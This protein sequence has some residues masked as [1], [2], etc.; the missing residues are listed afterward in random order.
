MLSVVP[1]HHHCNMH[2]LSRK[3]RFLWG[4]KGFYTPNNIQ[5]MQSKVSDSACFCIE[6]N[7]AQQQVQDKTCV[8]KCLKLYCM[9]MLEDVHNFATTGMCRFTFH[10]G[11]QSL[12]VPKAPFLGT[13]RNEQMQG[14]GGKEVV[15][16][17]LRAKIQGIS[18]V[19]PHCYLRTQLTQ[20]RLFDVWC[21]RTSQ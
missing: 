16:M 13:E 9:I 18:N 17:Q 4:E 19:P 10:L 3:R 11:L 6:R 20:F 7:A 8:S 15:T 2:I 1:R 5:E 14:A 12:S 21:F